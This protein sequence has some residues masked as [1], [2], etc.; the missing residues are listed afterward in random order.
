VITAGRAALAIFASHFRLLRYFADV[1]LTE[2]VDVTQLP[3]A[4]K[5]P[6]LFVGYLGRGSPNR[7]LSLSS[8]CFGSRA[9]T[10]GFFGFLFEPA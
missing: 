6:L 1:A 4:W 5:H 7:Q 10:D 8:P 2:A 3:T 9:F